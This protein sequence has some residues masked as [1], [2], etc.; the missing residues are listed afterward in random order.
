MKE[1]VYPVLDT[2]LLVKGKAGIRECPKYKVIWEHSTLY[3]RPGQSGRASFGAE[4]KNGKE[5]KGQ[6]GWVAGTSSAF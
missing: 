2:V 6:K 3:R 1:K 5:L 4:S